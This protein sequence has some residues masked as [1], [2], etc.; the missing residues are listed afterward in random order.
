MDLGPFAHAEHFRWFGRYDHRLSLSQ[1]YHL[2]PT[3][4]FIRANAY[5]VSTG[6]TLNTVDSTLGLANT[7]YSNIP[8]KLDGSAATARSTAHGVAPR[9]QRT[10]CAAER[11][12]ALGAQRAFE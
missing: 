5:V 2:Q 3:W 10:A 1:R 4:Q 11:R 6:M 7:G 9:T 8:A 12:Y